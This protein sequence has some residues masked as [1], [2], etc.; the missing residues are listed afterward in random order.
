MT[1][2]VSADTPS[3]ER[4]GEVHLLDGSELPPVGLRQQRQR[5][6]AT[7]RIEATWGELER[8]MMR[9]VQTAS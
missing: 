7:E 1:V 4:A 5:E 8:S 9:R 6:V 2:V 3:A